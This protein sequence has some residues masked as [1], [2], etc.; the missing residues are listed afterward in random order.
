M[1]AAT[2]Q[3]Q[4]LRREEREGRLP[5]AGP[6]LDPLRAQDQPLF[7]QKLKELCPDCEVLYQNADAD[8]AKQQQQATSAITQG[9]KVIVIDPVDAAATPRR[10]QAQGAGIK[11]IAYD[12]P[13]PEAPADFYV[14]FDNEKIGKLD[15]PVAGR[16]P[17]ADDRP[18]AASWRST[19]RR[20]TRPP[21]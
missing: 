9:A 15:R 14:S 20:R 1:A 4:Q 19:A 2:E 10:S 18:R 21:A 3:Q 5:D 17:Q 8:A 13:I 11:V 16:P 7:E 6:G 12:R